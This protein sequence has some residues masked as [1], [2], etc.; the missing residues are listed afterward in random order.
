MASKKMSDVWNFFKIHESDHDKTVCNLCSITLS[1]KSNST[2]SMWNHLK[3]KHAHAM[4]DNKGTVLQKF[5]TVSSKQT[6]ITSF[7][8]APQFSKDKQQECYRAAAEVRLILKFCCNC[9]I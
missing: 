9:C 1:Y 6:S 4:A 3:A 8:R 7:S 2:K 5:G